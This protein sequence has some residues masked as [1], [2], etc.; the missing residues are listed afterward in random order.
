MT[1]SDERLLEACRRGDESAWEL[2]VERYQRLLYAIPRRAGLDKD[3]AAEVFQ[4][5]FMTL[6]EK[7]DDIEQPDR[8]QA[9]LVTTARRKTW[10]L[11]S[12]ENRLQNPAGDEEENESEL[13]KLVDTAQLPD[14]VL[15]RLEEQHRVRT[16]LA[17]LDE[18]CRKLLTML[19]YEPE[20]PPYAE[21]AAAIGT[22]EGSI[23]PTR[24]RC[25]KK[26]MRQLAS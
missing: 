14:E 9:W 18:R 5:V 7:L 15:M 16:A 1:L 3:Q 6:L 10:R 17:Q 23:G 25:L 2:L 19:F 12:R 24:A 26:L 20:P 21:I 8:L 22:T 11:I 4:E 13:D